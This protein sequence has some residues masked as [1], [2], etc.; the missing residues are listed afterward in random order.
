MEG[1]SSLNLPTVVRILDR[2]YHRDRNYQKQQ[3]D[4]FFQVRAQ[5]DF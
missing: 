2:N 3:R 4:S 1:K 5:P